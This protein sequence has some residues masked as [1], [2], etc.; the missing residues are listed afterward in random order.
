MT[1]FFAV[2][3]AKSGLMWLGALTLGWGIAAGQTTVDLRTQSKNVDFSNAPET[4]PVKTGTSLP[5]TCNTGDFFFNT[6]A[7]PGSNLYGCT[8]TNI[9]SQL[10]GGSGS[11]GGSSS[12]NPAALSVSASGNA[13]TIGATCSGSTPC[14]V[15]V[16]STVFNFTTSATATITSGTGA[17]FVYIDNTGTLTVGHNFGSGALSCSGL[18]VAVNGI[19]AYPPD[20]IPIWTW[21][22]TSGTWDSS[23]GTDQRAFLSQKVVSCGSGLQCTNT[24]TVLTISNTGS[25]GSGGGTGLTSPL[26]DF[27]D[28]SS[29]ATTSAQTLT[30]LTLA[31]NAMAANNDYAILSISGLQATSS[32]QV[33]LKFGNTAV[34]LGNSA[35]PWSLAAGTTFTAECKVIRTASNAEKISCVSGLGQNLAG[36]Y[37]TFTTGAEDLT[38]NVT[39]TVSATTNGNAGDVVLKTI[40]F[41]P[42]NF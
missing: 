31:G 41:R 24:G 2:P 37:V 6:T 33:T 26:V 3:R 15:R 18:C 27:S 8:A 4:R 12:G 19:T 40:E 42:V 7:A 34:L 39:I 30:T 5:A 35:S 28:H 13:L 21:T 9:W 16:G 20:S 36:P 17:A 1:K 10:A 29:T 14:N 32:N 22:A 23:G 25:S 38:A 11:G